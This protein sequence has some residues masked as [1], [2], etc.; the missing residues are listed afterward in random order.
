MS[1]NTAHAE[2]QTSEIS[3]KSQITT[4]VNKLKAIPPEK[5]IL[6]DVENHIQ[7]LC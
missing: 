4:E 5:E 1:V 2:L 3:S 6:S 7:A